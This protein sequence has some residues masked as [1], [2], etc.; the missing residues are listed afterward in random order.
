MSEN[1]FNI[2]TAS[3][4]ELT[5]AFTNNEITLNQ[6]MAETARRATVEAEKKAAKQIA[7]AVA[8]ANPE[9]AA[10]DQWVHNHQPIDMVYCAAQGCN[11]HV[12]SDFE[13]HS[14]R[15]TKTSW[16]MD[17]SGRLKTINVY[18]AGSSVNRNRLSNH[19]STLANNFFCE[20][21]VLSTEPWAKNSL[22]VVTIR[23]VPKASK[24]DNGES[25]NEPENSDDAP[26][27]GRG[28]AQR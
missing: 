4:E 20:G 28:S 17:D 11:G 1:N 2:E 9:K 8:N 23:F 10:W 7:K 27:R 24:S 6:L 5:Q 22:S 14:S 15:V 25:E 12:A 26:Q 16:S 19:L 3:S 13:L 21:G 18:D